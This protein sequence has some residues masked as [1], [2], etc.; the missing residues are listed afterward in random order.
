MATL[1]STIFFLWFGRC[2][3]TDIVH[4]DVTG[5]PFLRL[6]SRFLNDGAFYELHALHI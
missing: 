6:A 5:Q 3:G 2:A 1:A 4:A